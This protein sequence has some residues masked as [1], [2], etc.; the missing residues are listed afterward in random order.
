MVLYKVLGNIDELQYR[1]ALTA[2]HCGTDILVTTTT[3]GEALLSGKA[4]DPVD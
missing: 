2:L 3:G 1:H 4:Q